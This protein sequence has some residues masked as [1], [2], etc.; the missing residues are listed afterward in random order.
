MEKQMIKVKCYNCY[1][2]YEIDIDEYY[3]MWKKIRGVRA[4]REAYGEGD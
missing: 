1:K 3:K 4:L 2:E